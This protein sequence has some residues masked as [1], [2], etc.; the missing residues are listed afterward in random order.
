LTAYVGKIN[1]LFRTRD[2]GQTWQES[3]EGISGDSRKILLQHVMSTRL[4]GDLLMTTDGGAT[5][6]SVNIPGP[7]PFS[8]AAEFVSALA[9]DLATP[10]TIYA[11]T[12]GE[13]FYKSVDGGTS[14]AGIS[15]AISQASVS[16]L[17]VDEATGAIYAGA[18]PTAL[19][20]TA[21]WKSTDGGF[22]FSSAAEGMPNSGVNSIVLSPEE[23]EHLYAATQN[24]GVFVTRDGAKSWSALNT[25]L[26]FLDVHRLALA[27][28]GGSLHA[29]TDAGVFDFTFLPD[30]PPILLAPR[31]RPVLTRALLGTRP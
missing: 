25:G 24:D 26:E 7:G 23:P 30:R 31:P 1:G 22:S 8:S 5:W 2:G 3:D 10:T 16:A 4:P 18:I 6:T 17:V 9:F 27:E 14:W 20:D 11:G 29:A 12:E 21:L 28:S 19:S 15:N 13:G